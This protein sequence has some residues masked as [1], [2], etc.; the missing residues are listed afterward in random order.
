MSMKV[1]PAGGSHISSALPRMRYTRMN[2]NDLAF[3]K[4]AAAT[5]IECVK[6]YTRELHRVARVSWLQKKISNDA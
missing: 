4:F 3:M 5:R 6:V 1:L 2:T